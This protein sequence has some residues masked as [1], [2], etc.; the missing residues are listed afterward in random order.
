MAGDAF[1]GFRHKKLW[2]PCKIFTLNAASLTILAVAMKLAVDISTNIPGKKDQLAKLSSTAF[3]CTAIGNFMPSLGKM[4]DKEILMNVIALAILVI[5]ILGNVCIQLGTGLLYSFL[6]IEHIAVMFLMFV[7]LVILSFSALTVS[8]TKKHLQLKYS[9][10][11]QSTSGEVELEDI[12]MVTVQKLRDYVKKYWMMAETGSPQFV[13]ARSVTC[14]ASGA[15]CSLTTI[16]L[17]EAE[18]RTYL[19]FTYTNLADFFILNWNNSSDYQWS[20]LFVLVIQ[21]IGVG[22]G[23]IA[24]VFRWFI[25]IKSKCSVRRGKSYKT[26]WKTEDYWTRR[27]V[28]WRDSP[29]ALCFRSK[30]FRKFVH[31]TKNRILNFCI[32]VQIVIVTASK[33]LLLISSFLPSLLFSCFSY[34][35]VLKRKILSK[36]NASSNHTGSESEPEP[37]TQLVDHSDFVLYLDG[38]E[39]IPLHIMK[40]INN[41]A[42]NLIQIGKKKPPKFLKEL[43]GKSTGFKG[44]ANFDS[45][46]IPSLLSEEPPN[47]W[48]LP[49]VTLTS[50]AMALPN[51]ENQKMERL[52]S[53]VNESLLYVR[54][55]EKILDSEADLVNIRNA[56]KS[57]WSEVDLSGKWLDEDLRKI[58][59]EGKT[60]EE[61]LERLAGMAESIVKEFRANMNG[62][63][64]VIAAN[65]MYRIS[66]TVLLNHERSNNQTD[67]RLFEQLSVMIADILGACLTNLPRVIT[68]K[69]FCSA[70]EEREKSVQRAAQLLGETEE[71]LEILQQ[72]EIPRLNPIQAANINE[73]RVSMKK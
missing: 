52:Q 20:I 59:L 69:C 15:I 44:V 40:T 4:D 12:G 29:L 19:W 9:D 72:R 31:N 47:C 24:P 61:T 13:I 70:I 63:L 7:L 58:A 38:E 32:G 21:T 27:L 67:E 28:G 2:F 17:A 56:A 34:C 41:A 14:S 5:T 45:N 54:Q 10:L 73:W 8:T 11:H 26:E 35:K 39:E 48:T 36:S 53:N 49:L 55:V 57:V 46:Q 68:M 23:T 25:V 18:L 43:L 60:S 71:T 16:I 66:K 37:G 65:S 1:H 33:S 62:N 22:V 64:K 50:I 3:M 42:D 51:I 30:K 6:M